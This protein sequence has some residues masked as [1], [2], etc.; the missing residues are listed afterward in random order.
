MKMLKSFKYILLLSA[1]ILVMMIIKVH[2]NNAWQ[3]NAGKAAESTV[4]RTQF[5]SMDELQ[6][7]GGPVTMI[8]PGNAVSDNRLSSFPVLDVSWEE[9]LKKEFLRKL[10][11]MNYKYVIVSGSRSDVMKAWVLLDQAGVKNLFVLSE[12]G[13][14]DEL[15]KYQ[16]QPDTTLRLELENSDER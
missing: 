15:F 2:K 1:I 12:E 16:F 3:G 4:L 5:I 10:N 13:M 6:K 9:I 14:N 7:G 11:Q 8:R